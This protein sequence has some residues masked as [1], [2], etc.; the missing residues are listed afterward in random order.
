MN[1]LLYVSGKKDRIPVDSLKTITTLPTRM[2]DQE[3]VNYVLITLESVPEPPPRDLGSSTTSPA[4]VILP[5]SPRL[6]YSATYDL[7]SPTS[8]GHLDF[9]PTIFEE[10]DQPPDSYVLWHNRFIMCR[11]RIRCAQ[12]VVS[13]SY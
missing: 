12:L 13:M 2:Q 1:F 10:D 8:F 11:R 6:D 3:W 4:N 7:A 5:D 9:L